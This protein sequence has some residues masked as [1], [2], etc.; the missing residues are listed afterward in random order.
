[1]FK[2]CS[3]WKIYY[4]I[5]C[6]PKM[7]AAHSCS[8]NPESI[9]ALS[10][11]NSC[12]GWAT[13]VLICAFVKS[14]LILVEDQDSKNKQKKYVFVR[15]CQ[16]PLVVP[17]KEMRGEKRMQTLAKMLFLNSRDAQWDRLLSVNH[18]TVKNTF[19]KL[20]LCYF[21]PQPVS[22]ILHIYTLF[23]GYAVDGTLDALL[24][25]WVLSDFFFALKWQSF[26]C[27]YCFATQ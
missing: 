22:S 12:Q 20:P 25:E 14:I 24:G 16:Q 1:M 21:F 23:W 18:I 7:L 26:F 17:A 5:I 10:I 11:L 9:P 27:L 6:F 4:S 19:S 15:R 3:W 13:P 8:F 2:F